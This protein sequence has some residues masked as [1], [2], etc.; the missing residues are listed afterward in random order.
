MNYK[1]LLYL[2]LTGFL[3]TLF[4]ILPS[5]VHEPLTLEGIDTVCFNTQVLPVLQ[6]SCGMVGC[7][8][9]GSA[10]GEFSVADYASVLEAVDPGNPSRSRLYRVLTDINGENMMPPNHPL[11]KPQRTLIAVWI[12]QGAKNTICS[13]GNTTGNTGNTG[14]IATS[15][16]ICFTQDILPVLRSSCATTGCHDQV[17]QREGYVFTD[18]STLMQRSG[19]VVPFYPDQSKVYRVMT[20]GESE[21]RM[22]P[23]GSQQLTSQQ[24]ENFRKWIAE[25]ALNSDCPQASCDTTGTISFASQVWPIIQNNCTGCHNSSLSNGGVNL[26]SYQQVKYYAETLRNGVPIIDGAIRQMN[27]FFPMPPSGSL[28]ECTIRKIEL[29]ID[30]GRLN[31]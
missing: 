13:T 20:T 12:A 8:G 14:G 30:Q 26:D 2:I 27:G 22:P 31:N 7:H 25:G 21:D 6:T 23:A 5:C 18:Y 17:T 19:S 29:W 24:I 11:A 9:N 4:F 15:D 1:H 10:R 28:D 16:S 3:L